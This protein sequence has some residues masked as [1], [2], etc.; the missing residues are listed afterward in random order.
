MAKTRSTALRGN[1]INGFVLAGGH[2]R[3]MGQD[4]ALLPWNGRSLLDHMTHLLSTV[5]GEVRV[6]GRGDLPDKIPEK[7][8]LGGILTA[9]QITSASRNL[10]VAVDL[11]FLPESFLQVFRERILRSKKQLVACKAG[12]DYPLCLGLDRALLPAVARRIATGKLALREFV[13]ETPAEILDE[14]SLYAAGFEP[15]IFNN[16]NTPED[17]QRLSNRESQK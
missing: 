9:L 12:S 7:G 5:A 3:R 8:P 6:I 13:E 14:A 11:P 2:S 4:K 17:W 1:S 15:F 10:V 16:L